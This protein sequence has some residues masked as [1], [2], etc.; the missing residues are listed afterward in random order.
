LGGAG[1]GGG[2]AGAGGGGGVTV[3]QG[4]VSVETEPGGGGESKSGGGA[5]MGETGEEDT[6]GTGLVDGLEKLRRKWREEQ[7]R[8]AAG[9]L[10]RAGGGEKWAESRVAWLALRALNGSALRDTLQDLKCGRDVVLSVAKFGLVLKVDK[11]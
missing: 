3:A 10:G 4:L 9:L 6:Y 11:N 5:V 8:A 1:D 7:G 2:R